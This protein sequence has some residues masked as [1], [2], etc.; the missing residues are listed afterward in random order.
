METNQVH[1]NVRKILQEKLNEKFA[2]RSIKPKNLQTGKSKP[3]KSISLLKTGSSIKQ[4]TVEDVYDTEE[5]NQQGG[6][7]EI[8]KHI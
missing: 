3:S 8:M 7:R 1:A 2:T 6:A 4:L 5:L